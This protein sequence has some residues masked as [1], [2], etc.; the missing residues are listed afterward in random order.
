MT[1]H[2]R[3]HLAPSFFTEKEKFLF[4]SG[5]LRASVFRYD[6]DIAALRLSNSLGEIICLPFQGQQVWS[7]I[8]NERPLHMKSMFTDPRPTRE[9]LQNYGAFLVHCGM[10][11]MG[12][13]SKDDTHPLH[14]ELPHATYAKAYLELGEDERG[15]YMALGGL[16]QH[17]I[18]FSTNYTAEPLT[19]LYAGSSL[20]S[21][22][23][24]VNNLKNTPQEYMYMA[25]VNF[26]PVDH[27]RFVYTAPATTEY[28]QVRPMAPHLKFPANYKDFIEDLGAHPE[29]HHVLIPGTPYDPEAVLYIKYLA[30]EGGWAHSMQV[31]PDGGADYIKH[32]PDQLDH[33]VRWISRTPD[34]DCLGIVL[35]ATA[36]ADGYTI[37]KS[38]GNVK[39]LP[40]HGTFH[41]EVVAGAVD[42]ADAAKIEAKV[43][44]IINIDKR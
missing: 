20:L 24:T 29:K 9:Y 31:H 11:A 8:F 44:G 28:I 23:M 30:D 39:T 32:R 35:P 4:E 17:T 14:G 37:E 16:Y 10:T 42:K 18:A 12:V 19:K 3:L 43:D 40:P 36:K 6:S 34:Q 33:G 7:V 27:G 22:C 26:R 15:A 1:V 13:P 25:H 38:R 41:C 21:M 5:E 2:S